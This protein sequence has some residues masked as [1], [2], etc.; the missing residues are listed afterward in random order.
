MNTIGQPVSRVD[1]QLKVTGRVRYTA[2]I[3]IEG[4]LHAAIVHSTIANGRTV[5]ID[6]TAAANAPGVVAVFTHSNM[7]R[8]NPTPRPWSHLHPHGQSYLPLQDDQI[9][10]AGQPLALIVAHTLDQ[11]IYA[12]RLINVNYEVYP[13][14]VFGPDT[15]KDAVQPPQFLWPV[16]SSVGDSEKGIATADVKIEQTYTTADRHH[17][18]MEPH[19]TIAVWNRDGTL[20]LYD[21]TQHIF[22]TRELVSMVLGI[23]QEKINVIAEFL[24]GGFGCKAYVWP[25]TLFAALAAKVLERPVRV[26]LTRAQMYSM[27][28][29]PATIQTLALGATKHGKLTGIRHD[30]ISPTPIFD[31]YIEYAA[32]CPRSLWA[33]SEGIWTNHKIVHVNRNT[34]TA[35]RAPHEAVGHFALESAMDELAYATGIDPVELRLL[36]DTDI[37]P[38]TGRP[39]STRAMRKCLKEAAV[40]FGW[41]K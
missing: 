40:L 1:S 13:A 4:L 16:A 41:H 9:H 14:I 20:T 25:H 39:F 26:Q 21:T 12:G 38:D 33:A 32:L 24:G 30:S 34:P 2:D 11:A 31:N 27:V 23:P 3:P 35:L 10:Y 17:N 28:G 5:S 29:Q 37:D 7:P 22:G 18:P 19:A 36:N 6:T 15:I 8:M